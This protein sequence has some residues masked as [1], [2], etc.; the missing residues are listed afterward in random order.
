MARYL[1]A[2]ASGQTTEVAGE[3]LAEKLEPDDEVFVLIIEEAGE[4]DA[5]A[6]LDVAHIEL[7]GTARV[8]TFRRSGTP[9]R[10]VVGFAHS[11]NVDEIVVGPSGVAESGRSGLPRGRT[12]P[13]WTCPCSASQRGRP[14]GGRNTRYGRGPD[15]RTG[16]TSSDRDPRAA[17]QPGRVTGVAHCTPAVVPFRYKNSRPGRF[18]SK[19]D[20][21]R[22]RD[23]VSAR[24]VGGR[25]LTGIVD[26][27]RGS[28]PRGGA[29]R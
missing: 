21:A 29:R 1:V 23:S 8:R 17:L 18:G 6:S 20:G 24:T 22:A 15:R 12:S 13:G 2:T 5:E 27:I 16:G 11:R 14:D 26:P 25:D 10:E 28:L 19:G 7:S 3:Y 9:A 4:P